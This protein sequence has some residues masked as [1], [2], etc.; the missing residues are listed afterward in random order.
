MRTRKTQKYDEILSPIQLQAIDGLMLGEKLV[1]LSKRLD[2]PYDTLWRWTKNEIFA[3][4]LN[5][6][7]RELVEASQSRIL[8]ASRMAIDTLIEGMRDPDPNIKIRCAQTILSRLPAIEL[9]PVTDWEDKIR[10][11]A[12]NLANADDAS[13]DPAI[14]ELLESLGVSDFIKKSNQYHQEL[15]DTAIDG[16]KA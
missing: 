4:E 9:P 12:E 7:K 6:R 10:Q 8:S 16:L 2:I 11:R 3:G 15:L 14:G 5:R 13:D 1:H